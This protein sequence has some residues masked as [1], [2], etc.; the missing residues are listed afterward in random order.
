MGE[1][2]RTFY[3]DT[4]NN[5]TIGLITGSAAYQRFPNVPGSLFRLKAPSTNYKSV[6]VGVT[7]GSINFELDTGEDTGWFTLASHNLNTMFWYSVSGTK[8]RLT[9]WAQN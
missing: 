1:T 3:S 7:S 6:W 5:D 9:Y 8:D 4:F 2:Y